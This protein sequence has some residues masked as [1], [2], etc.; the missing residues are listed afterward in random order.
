MRQAILIS[1]A[2]KCITA[3]RL[4]TMPTLQA[5]QKHMELRGQNGIRFQRLEGNIVDDHVNVAYNP[6]HILLEDAIGGG[7]TWKRP[8]FFK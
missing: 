5:T 2:A 4:Q 7:S 6:Q 1:Q 8:V 3:H